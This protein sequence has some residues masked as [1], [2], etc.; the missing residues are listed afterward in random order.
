MEVTIP[1][2]YSPRPYQKPLWAAIQRGI[3]RL[4]VVWHRRSGK[5]KTIVNI[6]ASESQKRV[7]TYFYFF[8]TYAQGKKILWDGTDKDGFRF[9]DHF[10]KEIIKNKNETELRIEFKNGSAFQ[11]IGTDKIDS[12]VGTNPIGCVFSEYSLQDPKA[13]DLMRPILRENG[14][15]A[16]FNFTPRGVNHGFKILQVAKDNPD[17]WFHQVLTVD[18]THAVSQEDIDAE[19]REGMPEELIQQ[20]FY[21]KFL[22]DAGAVFRRVRE[23]TYPMDTVLAQVGDFQVGADFAKHHDWTVLTP[24]NLNHFIVYPQERFNQVDWNLQKAKVEAMCYR[25]QNMNG[26]LPLLWPDA[27]GVGDPIVEDLK[28]RGLRIGGENEEGFKFTKIS[29]PNLLKNLSMLIEQ[30]KIKLPNDEGLISELLSMRYELTERGEVQMKVPDGMHDD[31]IMSCALS[32]WG[33]VSPIRP[34]YDMMDKVYKNRQTKKS[35]Q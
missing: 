5:D 3:K 21:C 33:V 18:D 26:D 34:D 27:T 25:H 17:T 32:V 22:D 20:E 11:I 1:H 9:L 6:V 23:N 19:R 14:G 15:W 30:D 8:P 24:F 12:I 4:V 10:P 2:K 31:R 35:F 28:G 29:R 13:W 7:G 16:I